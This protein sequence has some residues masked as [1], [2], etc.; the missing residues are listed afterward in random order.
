MT[1]IVEFWVVARGGALEPKKKGKKT[2][3]PF[4]RVVAFS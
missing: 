1:K 4:K 2:T 3:I